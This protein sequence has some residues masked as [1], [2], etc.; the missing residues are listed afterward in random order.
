MIDLLSKGLR[1]CCIGVGDS[2]QHFGIKEHHFRPM[3]MMRAPLR[4]E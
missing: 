4:T 3:S 2:F 1:W